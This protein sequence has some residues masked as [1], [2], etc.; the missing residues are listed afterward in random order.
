MTEQ[1]SRHISACPL[2]IHRA[3]LR[4]F[5]WASLLAIGCSIKVNAGETAI[6]WSSDPIGPGQTAILVGNGFSAENQVEVR[7]QHNSTE[8]SYSPA[9]VLQASGTSI[10]FVVPA[11]LPQGVFAYRVRTREGTV[12]GLLNH[13]QLWWILGDKG[14]SATPGGSIRLFGKNFVVQGAS[15]G[16]KAAVRLRGPRNVI[17]SA[18]AERYSAEAQLPDDLPCGQ[19]A[20][21][22]HNG[23][24]GETAC[25]A[26]IVLDVRVAKPWPA[27]LF[28]VK[29]MGAVG[30]GVKD[31]TMAIAAALKQAAQTSGGVVYF[32]RG[33]YRVSETLVV[34]RYTVLRG[35][36]QSLVALAWTSLPD[37]PE[38]LVL[39]TNSFGLEDLTLYAKHHRHIIVGDL[40]SQPESGNIHLH[41]VR[42]RASRYRGHPTADDVDQLYRSSLQIPGASRGDTVRLGGRNVEIIDCDL[43]GSGRSLFLS[44]VRG[45]RV[46]GNRLY[47]GRRGWYCIA[48]SDGL[49]FSNNEVTGAD[50]QA[51]GGGLNCLDGSAYSQNVYYARNRL[52]LMHG[53]D[54]EAMTSDAGGQAY[55]GKIASV[56][57]TRLTLADEPKWRNRD[58]SGAGVFV[59]DGRGAGQYRRVASCDGKIVEIDRPWQIAPDEDSSLSITMFQ[60]HYVLVGNEF[61]DTGAVQ[62]YGISIENI[63]D[64]NIGT[65]MPGF[66]CLGLCYHGYQPSW[67]CQLL[68]NTIREGNYYHW[69][70]ATQATLKIFGATRAPFEGP[71]NRA[72]VVRDNRLENNAMIRVYGTCRDAIVEDNQIADS[73]QGI[74]VSEKTDGVLVRNNTFENVAYS[75]V[76]E[77]AERAAE[78]A[79]IKHFV[80]SEAPVANWHFDEAFAGGF[81]DS[82]GNGF[83]AKVAGD[84]KLELVDEAKRGHALR[85]DGTGWLRVEEP[86][87]FNVPN[88]SLCF[89]MKPDKSSGKY[90]LL[91]KRF[92][93]TVAPF[94]ICQMETR[95]RVAAAEADGLW[96]FN[97]NSPEVLSKDNWTHVGIVF[98]AGKGLTIYA[99]GKPIVQKANPG[100]RVITREP[101]IIGREAWGG[102][103]PDTSSPGIYS[104]LLDE[105]K[106]W[107]RALS[108]EEVEADF[109][110]LDGKKP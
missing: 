9:E 106:I 104:G 15:S 102:D 103:P 101:L 4:P 31:D 110:T 29:S 63:I 47:N 68:N 20:V 66:S 100:E 19:Y 71:L 14:T 83:H 67:F 35:E 65:R 70:S 90:G 60:G 51:S 25:S 88:I 11:D 13:P 97:T 94:V 5:L 98:Q 16:A 79:R 107:A 56:H 80:D 55:F 48:G 53:W 77:A 32:P 36:G 82:S 89:W 78:L 26:S 75:V 22:V 10:K 23:C 40:G 52:R 50:L 72:A 41:R 85:F 7:V 62:F 58:W 1:S 99:N 86:A 64:G 3:L 57:G 24:G 37:P 38:A 84:G 49:V 93:G 109:K 12:S 81:P 27:T 54:R 42:V 87:V 74:F 17:L 76:D 45:G 105:V 108:D 33:R 2:L 34:P 59:L 69:T 96:S 6:F 21:S 18:Q 44:R 92:S 46:E 28:D 61:T 91:V 95:L 73:E 8:T 39:G 43:Y 30:D